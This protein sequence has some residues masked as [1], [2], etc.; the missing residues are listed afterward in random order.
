MSKLTLDSAITDLE[1]SVRTLNCL[2]HCYHPRPPESVTVRELV[3]TPHAELLQ[4]PNFGVKSN[5]ELVDTLD[6]NQIPHNFTRLGRWQRAKEYSRPQ[7]STET[8]AVLGRRIIALKRAYGEQH[9]DYPVEVWKREVVNDQT[10]LGYWEWV[11]QCDMLKRQE[12]ART[13]P[14]KLKTGTPEWRKMLHDI[15]TKNRGFSDED[16]AR[17]ILDGHSI[18]EAAEHFGRSKGRIAQINVRGRRALG[19]PT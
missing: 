18:S 3:S 10:Q 7:S 9:P 13:F 2:R 12:G 15:S 19:L 16:V 1:V 5:N 14:T 8:G 6:H 17:Y 4:M 11:R